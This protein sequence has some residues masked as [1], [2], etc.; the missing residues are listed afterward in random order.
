MPKTVRKQSEDAA[1]KRNR[2]KRMAVRLPDMMI[3]EI[4][5]IVNEFPELGYNR[6]QFVESAVRERLLTLKGLEAGLQGEAARRLLRG[7]P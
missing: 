2:P 5:R 6:Q 1:G 3:E 7:Q 4:D